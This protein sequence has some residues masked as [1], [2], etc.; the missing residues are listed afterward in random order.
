MPLITSKISQT[1]TIGENTIVKANVTIGDNTTIGENC[2][3]Y[4]NVV[5]GENCVVKN[6]VII[7]SNTVIGADAFY[8]KKRDDVYHKMKSCGNV[9]I[10]DDVEIGALC[11]IDRGVS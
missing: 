6:N 11:T 3:I 5:I 7:H 2:I 9:I 1:A 8:Y 4:P 10:E